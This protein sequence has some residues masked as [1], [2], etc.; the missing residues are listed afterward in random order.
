MYRTK[1]FNNILDGMQVLFTDLD[2]VFDLGIDKSKV[3]AYTEIIRAEK[4]EEGYDI[5]FV[6]PGYDKED[7]KISLEKRD[8]VVSA[9]F[10]KEDTWK[11]SF[12]KRVQLPEDADFSKSVAAL[13]KG[14]LSIEVPFKENQKPVEIK[15]G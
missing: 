13:D 3:S 10:E 8:L 1:N 2:S 6:V 7:L 4:S 15:I 14:I 11:K 5:Y 9:K 12:T